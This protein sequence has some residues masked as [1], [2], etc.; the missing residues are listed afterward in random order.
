MRLLVILYIF[1]KKYIAVAVYDF[2]VGLESFLSHVLQCFSLFLH[3]EASPILRIRV[4]LVG[5]R[6]VGT[7]FWFVSF[8]FVFD[9]EE[10]LPVEVSCSHMLC[11]M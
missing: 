5:K 7:N 6:C 9:T 11:V 1:S 3:R 8:A 2:K 4:R 10:W